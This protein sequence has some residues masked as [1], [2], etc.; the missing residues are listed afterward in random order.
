MCIL[1]ILE[2]AY[3]IQ[4]CRP[5]R[6]AVYRLYVVVYTCAVGQWSQVTVDSS[7]QIKNKIIIIRLIRTSHQESINPDHPTKKVRGQHFDRERC[8]MLATS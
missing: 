8:P 1:C 2:Y 3:E 5:V 6:A 7:C 4:V